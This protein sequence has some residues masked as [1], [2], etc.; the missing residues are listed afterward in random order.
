MKSRTFIYHVCRSG[1]R[2]ISEVY[3]INFCQDKVRTKRY[4]PGVSKDC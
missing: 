1:T 2:T 3:M 4:T